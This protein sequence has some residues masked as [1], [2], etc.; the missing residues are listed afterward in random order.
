MTTFYHHIFFRAEVPKTHLREMK[1]IFPDLTS[2]E[3]L[4][5]VPT[6]QRAKLDL[7]NTGEEVE[8]EK[9]A[10]LE[11]FVSWAQIVCDR[12]S[13]AGYWCD[14]IDPCSGLPVCCFASSPT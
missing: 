13:K 8:K 4:F 3:D 1:T 7:V 14:F 5:I 9:D 11:S 2:I 12:L 6:C 10:L